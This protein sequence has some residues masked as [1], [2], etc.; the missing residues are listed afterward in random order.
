M[1]G[2]EHLSQDRVQVSLNPKPY[3]L[4]SEPETL[5]IEN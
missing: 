2:W 4:Y 1:G 5:K 3:V